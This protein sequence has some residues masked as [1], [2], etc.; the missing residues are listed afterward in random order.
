M[1][2]DPF[3]QKKA[4]FIRGSKKGLEVRDSLASGLEAMSEVVV[5]NTGRQTDVETQFQQVID[6]TTNKDVISA[7]EIIAARAGKPNLKTRIDDFENETTAQLAQTD[8]YST[9]NNKDILVPPTQPSIH[10]YFSDGN[11]FTMSDIDLFWE[12]TDLFRDLQADHSEYIKIRNHGTNT[13][14]W[15]ELFSYVYEPEKYEKTVILSAGVHGGEKLAIISLY[16]FLK[17]L[18]N[19]WQEYPALSYI[20]KHVRLIVIPIA[21]PSGVYF[22]TRTNGGTKLVD[23]NRNFPYRFDEYVGTE[24]KMPGT[25][26]G[27]EFE[28]QV[29]MTLLSEN[30]DAVA[31]I[32]AH[33]TGESEV[34]E[35]AEWYA[36]PEIWGNGDWDY[37]KYV[38]ESTSE[39]TGY[40]VRNSEF[41]APT[42]FNYATSE[43]G[44]LAF[45][46][47]YVPG[48]YGT[49]YESA[50]MTSALK[51][52][53]NVFIRACLLPAKKPKLFNSGGIRKKTD[54]F[55]YGA[56]GVDIQGTTLNRI[57]DFE[58]SLSVDFSGY[59]NVNFEMTFQ[60]KTE[61][62]SELTYLVPYAY[63]EN[64]FGRF[65]NFENDTSA[66]ENYRRYFEKYLRSNEATTVSF[67][68]YVPIVKGQGDLT[69]G[70]LAQST[71]ERMIVK[72]LTRSVEL[73]P[74]DSY[75]EQNM[76]Y[77]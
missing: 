10:S 26:G 11:A 65:R 16:N 5:D 12:Y 30:P 32:D 60:S 36:K 9:G 38:V 14:G 17:L 52:F 3:I 35:S 6:N 43:Y 21:N 64:S 27:S 25:H 33:N 47:E 2:V 70:F 61:T 46:P 34:D 29:I 74:T 18:V 71:G 56:D 57:L 53:A 62:E 4:D 63:Q 44:M 13:D 24:N 42:G 58:E 48:K 20:R 23:I 66:L 19:D 68:A 77:E 72:R 59:A 28:T 67:S 15:R 54:S 22:N 45:N 73:V 51:W 1:A 75:I 55:Y 41:I 8:W 31:W 50:D 76:F 49:A 7:P 37:T 40:E 39:I 69:F